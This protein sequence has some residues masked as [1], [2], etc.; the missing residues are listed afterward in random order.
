MRLPWRTAAA[1]AVA[2]IPPAAIGLWPAPRAPAAGLHQ[3]HGDH[4]PQTVRTHQGRLTTAVPAGVGAG[5][6][7]GKEGLGP[8]PA[9]G[10]VLEVGGKGGPD[11]LAAALSAASDG[12]RII[13]HGG[14]HPGNFTVD[15]RIWIEGRAGATLSGGG[16]GTVVTV[17]AP[18]ARITGLIIR[19]SGRTLDGEDSGVALKNADDAAVA[20]CTL[21]EVQFGVSAKGAARAVIIG[22]DVTGRAGD[23]SLMGDG[24]RA[25][26]SDGVRIAFNT[27][28]ATREILVESTA[29]AEVRGNAVLDGRQGLHLMRANGITVAGNYLG[30]NSTGIYVMYGADSRVEGNRVENNRGPSGYG[31]GLK[32]ADGAVITGNW[33]I[34]NRAGI[35]LD[36][37][38]LDPARPN[39]IADNLVAY[40]D[41]GVIVT[42]ATKGNQISTNDFLDNFQQVGVNGQG[43]PAANRWTADGRGNHWSDYAGYDADGD[44]VGD[45]PYAPVRIFEGW[46]DRQPELKWF[47]FTP[48]A[49]AVD[50]AARAFP[51]STGDPVLT[52]DRPAMAP[53]VRRDSP[54]SNS[55]K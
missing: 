38:P 29:G 39:R 49:S 14:W 36:S 46:M 55:I 47:W 4:S 17:T 53:A 48:A 50:L 45:L 12:D 8:W 13:L 18:G 54:W 20:G 3:Q 37:S 9:G 7:D 27:V 24:I 44:R 25:W 21:R 41:A 52:D 11:S 28:R 26:S 40:N 5:A 16:K 33:F 43:Q 51:L 30:G 6:W 1:L 34:G 31:V 10:R 2:L 32:E 35:Y 42:P 19:E 15:R 22:N 23:L